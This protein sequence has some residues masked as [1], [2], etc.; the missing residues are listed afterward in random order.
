M[1]W[2]EYED[3]ET[4]MDA[5]ATATEPN[6][7]KATIFESLKFDALIKKNRA[8]MHQIILMKCEDLGSFIITCH[9]RQ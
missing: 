7:S 1:E 5:K 3:K 8:T 9:I 4:R 2:D 6:H